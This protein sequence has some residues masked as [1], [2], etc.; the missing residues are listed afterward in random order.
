[1]QRGLV[2]FSF[3]SMIKVDWYRDVAYICGEE[4]YSEQLINQ[5]GHFH[6]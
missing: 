6:L 5:V 2:F 4:T 1:L 3:E